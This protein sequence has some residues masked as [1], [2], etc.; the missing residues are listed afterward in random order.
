MTRAVLSGAAIIA[1]VGIFLWQ[2]S[3][4]S[5]SEKIFEGRTKLPEAGALC[6]WRQPEADLKELFPKATHYKAETRILSGLRSE[7]ALR[8]GRTPTG[9]ENALRLYRVYE[10]KSMIGTVLTSR[11]KGQYGAIELV[12]GADSLGHVNGWHLQR[13]REPDSVAK[14]LETPAWQGWF[15][16]KDAESNWQI[17]D[18]IRAMPVEA[19]PSAQAVAQ[20]IRTL[21]ILLATADRSEAQGLVA[22]PHH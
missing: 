7:L 12:L 22:R 15:K 2:T 14:A 20:G 1:A 16:G 13:L 19:Q 4:V 6:P 9:D 3:R 21:L 8:L 10:G 18:E 5:P 17:D 11:V